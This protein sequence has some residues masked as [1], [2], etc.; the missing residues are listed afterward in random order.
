MSECARSG[1][2]WIISLNPQATSPPAGA[3]TSPRRASSLIQV[4]VE[5]EEQS[6][7][8]NSSAP[9]P[10]L[11]MAELRRDRSTA[12]H[13]SVLLTSDNGSRV[14]SAGSKTSVYQI[15]SLPLRSSSVRRVLFA[16]Q[17]K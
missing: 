3:T 8:N 17:H 4:T 15:P 14:G 7:S 11:A 2:F 5:A 13:T 6:N 10:T 16:N 1:T 12:V 9:V